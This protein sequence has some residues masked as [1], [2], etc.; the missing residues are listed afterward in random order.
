MNALKELGHRIY[1]VDTEPPSVRSLQGRLPFRIRTKLFRLG[2]NTISHPDLAGVNRTIVKSFEE[3]GFD[4]LWLDKGLTIEA[5]TLRQIK[6]IRPETLIVGYSPDDMYRRHNQSK[7]FLEHLSL[8]DC[9][10]LP[11]HTM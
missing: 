9:F 1:G 7:Q 5:A 11:S 3:K 4:I 6:Q 8:Y 2:W 10:S